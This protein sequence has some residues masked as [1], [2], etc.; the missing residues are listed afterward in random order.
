MRCL[1]LDAALGVEQA[2]E[3]VARELAAVNKGL[4]HLCLCLASAAPPALRRHRG[5]G[6]P[7]ARQDERRRR[8][9]R[10]APLGVEVL[11][12]TATL[13]EMVSSGFL[14]AAAPPAPVIQLSTLT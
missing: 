7:Q 12:F 13:P 2:L 6:L 14:V 9:D 4:V 8:L 5:H 10:L 3:D 11:C 1:S